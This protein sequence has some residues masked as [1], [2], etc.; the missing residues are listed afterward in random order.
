ML[1]IE[2]T[3]NTVKM[4]ASLGGDLSLEDILIDFM[5]HATVSGVSPNSLM[6]VKTG[7]QN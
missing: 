3:Q 4:L 2:I 7:S 6:E 5:S 1:D